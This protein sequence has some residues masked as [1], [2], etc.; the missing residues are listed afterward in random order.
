MVRSEAGGAIGGKPLLGKFFGN[1][2]PIDLVVYAAA[3]DVI[4]QRD[5]AGAIGEGR[6]VR[7]WH[8]IGVVLQSDIQIFD[9][10]R[11]ITN[12]RRFHS[13]AGGP[14]RNGRGIPDQTRCCRWRW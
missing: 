11:P 6:I 3:N 7:G 8:E 12:Q 13:A 2:Q 10:G 14:A 1:L 4:V 9:L 5:S